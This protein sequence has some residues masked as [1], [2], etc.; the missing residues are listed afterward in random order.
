MKI[1][2]AHRFELAQAGKPVPPNTDFIFLVNAMTYKSHPG[3]MKMKVVALGY[4]GQ[5]L[6]ARPTDKDITINYEP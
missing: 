2:A 3:T 6:Q 1:D 4:L 5:A